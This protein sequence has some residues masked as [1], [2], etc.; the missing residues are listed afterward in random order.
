ML[1]SK[2]K[3]NASMVGIFDMFDFFGPKPELKISE[4]SKLITKYGILVGFL[5]ILSIVVISSFLIEGFFS[6]DS[7]SV[8]YNQ[9][10]KKAVKFDISDVP[11]VIN[12]Y[13]GNGIPFK[14]RD[15]LFNIMG[16]TTTYGNILNPKTNKY[17]MTG[18]DTFH[19]FENCD[20]EKHFGNYKEYFEKIPYVAESTCYVT[21]SSN[22]TM[23]GKFG[24]T[25]NGYSVLSIVISRCVNGTLTG[26]N[27]IRDN[28]LPLD[29]INSM[30]STIFLTFNTLD[31]EIDHGNYLNPISFVMASERIQISTTTFKRQ[32]YKLRDVEYKTDYGLMFAD[33]KTENTYQLEQGDNNVDIRKEGFYPGSFANLSIIA[34]SKNDKYFRSYSKLQKLLAD[35]GGFINLVFT[36]SK[37]LIFF[38]TRKLYYL[39]IIN[40]NINEQVN[41]KNE[42]NHQLYSSKIIQIQNKSSTAKINSDSQHP[43]Q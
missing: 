18:V 26:Q 36:I 17:E 1:T 15:R 13:G 35:L 19:K 42:N 40:S 6:K 10:S 21:G 25:L 23:F 7:L 37:I 3:S 20:K 29:T 14:D 38:L 43:I 34:S 30:L 4:R 41:D 8:I 16:V 12:L 39:T 27:T 31:Y 9:D 5:A 22:L 11:F 24:D 32:F 33:I 2:A 28:C